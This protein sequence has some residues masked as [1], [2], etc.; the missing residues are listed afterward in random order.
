[1]VV[2][3]HQAKTHLSRLLQNVEA[4]QDVLIC[5]GK[6]PVARLISATGQTTAPPPVGIATSEPFEIPTDAFAPLSDSELREWG[7]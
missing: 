7:L 5:R 4:G 6:V 2:T 3:V 1:M